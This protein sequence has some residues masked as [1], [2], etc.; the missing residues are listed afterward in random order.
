MRQEVP[1]KPKYVSVQ[2]QSVIAALLVACLS[3]A[4]TGSTMTQRGP[5]HDDSIKALFP[6][7]RYGIRLLPSIMK[8]TE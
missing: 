5:Q 8:S 7:L 3:V 4:M 1:L 6:K 2:H